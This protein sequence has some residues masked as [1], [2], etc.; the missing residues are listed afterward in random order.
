MRLQLLIFGVCYLCGTL[1]LPAQTHL[2]DSLKQKLETLPPDTNRI[3]VLRRLAGIT[4]GKDHKASVSYGREGLA[5]AKSL[6]YAK[7]Q[8]QSYLS[9]SASYNAASGLDSALV[10]IDSAIDVAHTVDEPG[11]LALIYLNRADIKMQLK[12]L[13]SSMSDCSVALRYAEKANS[14]DVRARIFQ[15]IGSVYYHQD[16]YDHCKHYYKKAL[17]LYQKSGN[18]R[19]SGMVMN[20]MGNVSKHTGDPAA[21]IDYLHQALQISEKLGDLNSLALQYGNLSDVYVTIND[22]ASAEKYGKLSMKYAKE[23]ENNLFIAIAYA[24]F[25][26]LY[27][28]QKKI[29][30]AIDAS[31]QAYYL[32]VSEDDLQWQYTSADLLSDVYAAAGDYKNAYTYWKISSTLG[33]SLAR[34]QFNDDIALLQTAFKLDQ[35]DKEIGLLNKAREL[36]DQQVK[37]HRYLTIGSGMLIA[38]L[39]AGVLLLINRHRMKQRLAEMEVRNKIAADLHD[40]IG[41]S[42]SSIRLLCEIAAGRPQK[43]SY[44]QDLLKKISRNAHETIE[45]MGDIVWTIRADEATNER[46]EQRMQRVLEDI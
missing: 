44:L 18:N 17:E 31:E 14:D 42:V 28:R 23:L 40:E 38:L 21:A 19:M 39:I 3:K 15:T 26:E 20:N 16:K 29:Q 1:T 35:K 5:L 33:D 10:Y 8:A 22:Y 11:L 25:G 46:I 41:S 2:T 34:Q 45:R 12:D 30:Q 27:L 9:L 32:S 37:F 24:H 13:Q 7:G 4:S 43:D 36:Q 6:D